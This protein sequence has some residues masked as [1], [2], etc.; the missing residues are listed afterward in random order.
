MAGRAG[1]PDFNDKFGECITI[2][3][4][5]SQQEEIVEHFIEGEP[6][7][8]YSKVAVEP[9]LRTYV[10]SLLAS[11]FV[12]TYQEIIDFFS[13]TFYAHQYGDLKKIEK[14][15]SKILSLLEEW[16][17]I[18][19]SEDDFV[20]ASDLEKKRI[21]PTLLGKKVS[22]LYLDPLTAN[23]FIEC[24]KRAGS[25]NKK[26][27]TAFSFLQVIS[28][29]LEMRPLFQVKSSELDFIEAELINY[30][31]NLLSMEPS[32]YSH[33]YDNFLNSIKTS[34]IFKEWIDENSEEY[35]LEKYNVRPGE[36]K[37]K[38]NIADWLLYSLEELAILLKKH[39]L[40]TEIKKL[41]LRLK[42]GAKEELLP[43]LRIK[44]IGRVRARKLYNNRI[45]DVKDIRNSDITK[46]V[47]L[48]GK[49]TALSLKKQCGLDLNPEKIIVPEQ[50]KKGRKRKGQRNLGDF[51]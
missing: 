33:E 27:I 16:E 14:I 28:Y 12:S 19:N 46:L 4:S 18:S 47:Q 34:F 15:I 2:A 49:S 22:T 25:K 6:E 31:D 44:N 1:R 45:R 3:K 40:I 24:I 35:I 38:I 42:Y 20:S 17:F 21:K 11:G 9:V 13:K 41:R 29:S 26:D 10:L 39:F 50:K 7:P 48:L 5:E 36:L 8:I 43:L 23:Y 32:L 51:S 30:G 37:Y